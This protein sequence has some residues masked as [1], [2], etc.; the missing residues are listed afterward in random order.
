MR[1]CIC[2]NIVVSTVSVKCF[3]DKRTQGVIY[4]RQQ[5]SVRERTCA[6]FSELDVG[7]RVEDAAVPIGFNRLLT[8]IDVRTSFEYDGT[9]TGFCKYECR[10][11]TARAETDDYGAVIRTYFRKVKGGIRHNRNSLFFTRRLE[12]GG[13]FNLK[14]RI[15]IEHHRIHKQQFG[16]FSRIDGFFVY[17]KPRFRKAAEIS[18]AFQNLCRRR[19]CGIVVILRS[20]KILCK[21]YFNAP[22]YK[23]VSNL[24]H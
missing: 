5:L 21:R 6:A 22:Y 1:L 13:I 3:K 9:Q 16:A 10:K 19:K 2:Q 15:K 14:I 7:F 24:I 12:Y 18:G 23:S 11:H 8:C 20:Q 4:S 17:G